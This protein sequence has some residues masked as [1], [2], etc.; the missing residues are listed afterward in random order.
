MIGWKTINDIGNNIYIDD[1]NINQFAVYTF[2]GNGN[3]SVATNWVNNR[4]PPAVLPAGHEIIINPSQGG[5][6]VKDMPLT[7]TPG[8]K[9]TIMPGKILTIP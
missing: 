2:I 9:L 1:V 3:W 4:I 7:L 6:S 5:E 8:S